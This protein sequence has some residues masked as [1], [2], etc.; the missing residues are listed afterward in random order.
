[1]FA[2]SNGVETKE[3]TDL[4]PEGPSHF[5]FGLLTEFRNGIKPAGSVTHLTNTMGPNNF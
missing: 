3:T 2:K 1:M 4:N 5:T